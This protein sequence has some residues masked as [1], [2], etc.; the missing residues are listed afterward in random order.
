MRKLL[1]RLGLLLVSVALTLVI[2]E[3]AVRTWFS[4]RQSYSFEMWRYSTLLKWRVPDPRGHVHRPSARATLMGVPVSLNSGGLRGPEIP[5]RK[6]DG[7]F[8]V[9]VIGDSFTLGWGVEES[10]TY[11]R[12]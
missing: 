6:P 12:L 9:L 8:R 3:L 2:S 10:K 5:L 1:P 11:P 4:H 7:E